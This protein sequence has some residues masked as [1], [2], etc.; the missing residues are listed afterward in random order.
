MSQEQQQSESK[1]LDLSL[2]HKFIELH[3]QLVEKYGFEKAENF[4]ALL[5]ARFEYEHENGTLESLDPDSI[6]AMLDV[7]DMD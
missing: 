7:L 4:I 6:L 1:A 2:R 3:E 5:K